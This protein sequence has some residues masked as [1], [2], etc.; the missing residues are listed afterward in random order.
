MR[1]SGRPLTRRV[2]T[3]LI[4]GAAA[5]LCLATGCAWPRPAPKPVTP[6]MILGHWTA[7]DCATDL[8]VTKDGTFRFRNFFS[9]ASGE[10]LERPRLTG[11][12]HWY[13]EAGMGEPS[14]DLEFQKQI[15]SLE[16]QGTEDGKLALRYL[17]D[18]EDE[19][20]CVFHKQG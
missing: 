4:T 7:G 12:G 8:D 6:N 10:G 5:A 14:L 1:E 19:I 11:K 17:V 13:M 3:M 2:T 9:D 20:D 15:Y 18:V 16:Y